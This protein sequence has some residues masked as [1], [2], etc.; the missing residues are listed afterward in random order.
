MAEVQIVLAEQAVERVAFPDS[1]GKRLVLRGRRGDR[2]RR[3]WRLRLPAPS[4]VAASYLLFLEDDKVMMGKP[5]I[6]CF[7]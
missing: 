5:L 3:C 2:F 6:F 7:R 4:D 1:Q